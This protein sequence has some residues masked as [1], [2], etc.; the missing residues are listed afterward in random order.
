LSHLAIG[1]ASFFVEKLVSIT[2]IAIEI[3]QDPNFKPFPN[4]MC[5]LEDGT[6]ISYKEIKHQVWIPDLMDD[7]TFSYLVDMY[8]SL[9]VNQCTNM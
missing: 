7:K 1:G 3:R 9:M 8:Y 4:M 2:D 5:L 6:S